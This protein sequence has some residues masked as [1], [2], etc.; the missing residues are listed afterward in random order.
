MQVLSSALY[1]FAFFTYLSPVGADGCVFCEMRREKNFRFG[2]GHPGW[3]SL[4]VNFPEPMLMST[5]EISSRLFHQE[6]ATVRWVWKFFFYHLIVILVKL[7]I[8]VVFSYFSGKMKVWKHSAS[9]FVANWRIRLW[10]SAF[11]LQG[12]YFC[13]RK[14]GTKPTSEVILLSVDNL[15]CQIRRHNLPPIQP[16]L[17]RMWESGVAHFKLRNSEYQKP[18][19]IF[20]GTILGLG[21]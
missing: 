20:L 13:G 5:W 17:F 18:F 2:K 16:T 7:M 11:R 4:L 8:F 1:I 21:Q 19:G 9:T 3:S 10:K 14:T 6:D 15:C 12:N